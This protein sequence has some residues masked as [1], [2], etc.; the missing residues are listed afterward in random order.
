MLDLRHI[1]ENPE[2]VASALARRGGSIDLAPLLE[3]DAECRRMASEAEALKAEQNR[4][5]GRI[6]EARRSGADATEMLAAMKQIGDR[7]K[8]LAEQV[9]TL[10]ELVRNELLLLPNL[11]DASVPDGGGEADNVELRRVGTP[12]RFDFVA[13]PH[14]ELGEALGLMDFTRAAKISGARFAS[15]SGALARMER[16]LAAFMLDLHTSEHGFTEVVAPYLV[17]ARAMLGTG[18]LPKFADDLFKVTE[19]DLYLIPTAEVSVTNLFADE[20]LPGEQLPIRLAAFSPC[21]RREAGSYGKD[22]RGLIR[23]H[24]FHKVEMVTLVRPEESEAALERLT[25]CAEAVLKRLNL[26]YRVITLC[27]GDMGFGSARTHDIEV[28]LPAQDRYREISSCTNFRDF[29]ARRAGIRFK[30]AGGKPQ[31]VHT[32][33]GSGLAVGRALV[34]VMENYQR[35]DG[36]IDVPEVLQPYMG[37]LK[38]I[39]RP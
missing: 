25:G 33:N 24:Q 21:F 26:A 2:A 28:W 14:D 7:Q 13:K 20:V 17:N 27:T 37:G 31:L 1:R 12:P 35:V 30:D 36:G 18:Q 8:A 39:H 29:Q 10:E 3:R 6:A 32:L 19:D 15:Y 9:K 11:P 4:A 23:Q 34:A 38:V 16:A 5:S 22:T